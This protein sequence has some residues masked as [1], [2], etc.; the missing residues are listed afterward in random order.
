MAPLT[1]VLLAVLAKADERVSRV[2][3]LAVP[4]EVLEERICGRWIHKKSGRS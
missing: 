2:V 3:E 1:E 4:D